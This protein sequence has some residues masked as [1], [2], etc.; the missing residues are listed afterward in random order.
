MFLAV[1]I[2]VFS[3]A[4]LKLEFSWECGRRPVG[5]STEASHTI[6]GLRI[7]TALLMSR[8]IM[9]NEELLEALPLT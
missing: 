9:Y 2:R 1:V 4:L 3:T 6:E 7:G 8:G 5:D